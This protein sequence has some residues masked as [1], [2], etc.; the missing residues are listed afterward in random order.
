MNPICPIINTS[1]NWL[2]SNWDNVRSLAKKTILAIS[3]S[4]TILLPMAAALTLPIVSGEYTNTSLIEYSPTNTTSSEVGFVQD[5]AIITAVGLQTCFL[6]GGLLATDMHVNRTPL[7]QICPRAEDH[8]LFDEIIEEPSLPSLSGKSSPRK[9][10]EVLQLDKE[11]IVEETNRPEPIP[12]VDATTF[13]QAKAGSIALFAH[14]NRLTH[15]AI[16]MGQ[17]FL[18]LKKSDTNITHAAIVSGKQDDQS[19]SLYEIPNADSRISNIAYKLE[20]FKQNE[21]ALFLDPSLALPEEERTTFTEYLLQVSKRFIDYADK[22]QGD[23]NIKGLVRLGLESPVFSVSDW[24][25]LLD[26]LLEYEILAECERSTYIPKQIRYFCSEFVLKKMQLARL[27]QKCPELYEQIKSAIRFAPP[28]TNEERKKLVER[29]YQDSAKNG[30][31][32]Q[33]LQDPFFF[34]P[35]RSITPAHFMQFAKTHQIPIHRI[36]NPEGKPEQTLEAGISQWM[37]KSLSGEPIS[38]PTPMQCNMPEEIENHLRVLEQ[39]HFDQE[40]IDANDHSLECLVSFLLK[41]PEYQ[42]YSKETLICF[43]MQS[44]K[45]PL[46]ELASRIGSCIENT[47]TWGEQIKLALA[48]LAIDHSIDRLIGTGQLQHFLDTLLTEGISKDNPLSQQ[49]LIEMLFPTNDCSLFDINCLENLLAAEY[50]KQGLSEADVYKYGP[51]GILGMED[52][53]KALGIQYHSPIDRIKSFAMQYASEKAKKP[54]P[55]IERLL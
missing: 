11:S 18:N 26:D 24:I 12:I 21:Q 49:R 23:Y 31:F 39:K 8:D 19:I 7:Q 54:L 48:S 14:A 32:D 15:L 13:Q 40:P 50:M 4:P 35:S 20:D 36:T 34:M 30:T 47:F 45:G 44:I 38:P 53:F 33:L 1:S 25:S 16:A 5:A 51:L 9:E 17:E 10:K 3:S 43:L 27:I 52:I 29:L 46:P 28:T 42:G 22:I 6:I 37:K 2:Q 41:Q 55:F